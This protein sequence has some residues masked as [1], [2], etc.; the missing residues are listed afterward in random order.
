MCAFLPFEELCSVI[1][2]ISQ[3]SWHVA[4]SFSLLLVHPF[5]SMMDTTLMLKSLLPKGSTTRFSY[6]VSWYTPFS[7]SGI[8]FVFVI[9]AFIFA[10]WAR[11]DLVT[12]L[13]LYFMFSVQ[14]FAVLSCTSC[15]LSAWMFW[16]N[17]LSLVCFC[18]LCLI[19][20]L[21]NSEIFGTHYLFHNHKTE[22]QR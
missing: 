21:L 1:R 7:C 20:S 22:M 9:F 4:V 17:C 19:T 18:L 5:S 3:Y 2:K 13:S 15:H 6:H 10:A 8:C 12:L 11:T 14:V 16:L